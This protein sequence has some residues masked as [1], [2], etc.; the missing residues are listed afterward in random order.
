MGCPFEGA[1]EPKRVAD[2]TA[3]LIRKPSGLA[4]D[5]ESVCHQ[6]WAATKFLSEIRSVSARPRP[7]DVS[8]KYKR[9]LITF[10]HREL[11]LCTGMLATGIC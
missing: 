10:A 1:I 6:R 4:E 3:A 5:I 9:R 2:V 11:I 8:T 7:F